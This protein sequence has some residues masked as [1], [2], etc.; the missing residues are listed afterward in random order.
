MNTPDHFTIP[1]RRR[2][3]IRVGV[4]FPQ[5]EIGNVVSDIREFAVTTEAMGFT[6]LLAYDHV[7][8]GSLEA[9]PN[10]QGRYTSETPFHEVFVLFGYLAAVT[11]SLELVS[12]VLILPQR[13]T[14]LVA[15]QAAELDLLSG[16]RLRL[17]VGIGWN[18]IEYQALNEN[19][20]NRGRRI[21]EQISVLRAFWAQ[22]ILTYEGTWHHINHA[23]VLPLPLQRPIPIWIGA[24]AEVAVRRAARLAD[25][26]FANGGLNEGMER[27]L[28]ALYEELAANGRTLEDFG[29]EARIS[30]AQGTPDDW[31]RAFV[32]WQEK[33]IS[34]LSFVTMGG[35]FQTVAEHLRALESAYKAIEGM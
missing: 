17:G 35:R 20:R 34:H 9:H 24:S 19:F 8:G 29:L 10:L 26:F 2:D 25:G 28:T 27:Q 4:V 16:G 23:G 1:H 18:D 6:H 5:T 3:E 22:D 7:V 30:I 13:Q 21:E 12:G 14:T 31:K 11:T 15:K 33:G 32:A